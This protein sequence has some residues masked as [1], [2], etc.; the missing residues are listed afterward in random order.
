VLADGTELIPGLPLPASA[1]ADKPLPAGLGARTKEEE[2]RLINQVQD[3]LKFKMQ[4]VDLP[5]PLLH[6]PKQYEKVLK[7]TGFHLDEDGHILKGAVAKKK[8]GGIRGVGAG[9]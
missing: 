4:G 2:M 8:R 5:Q 3:Y 7:Q 6:R 1:G 9:K